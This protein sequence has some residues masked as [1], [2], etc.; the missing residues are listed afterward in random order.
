MESKDLLLVRAKVDV[1]RHS[2]DAACT[3]RIPRSDIAA[4][5]KREV[6]RLMN[7]SLAND[8]LRSG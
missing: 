1:E 6:L 4:A 8:S 7:H 5:R 3:V 2:H